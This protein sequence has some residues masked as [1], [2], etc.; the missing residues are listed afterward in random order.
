MTKFPLVVS[1]YTKNTP[2]EKWAEEL[3]NSC[4]KF[5]LEYDIEGVESLGSWHNNCCFKPTFLLKKIVQHKKPIFW[6]DADAIFLKE[7]ILLKYLDCDLAIRPFFKPDILH[8]WVCSG[9]IYLKYNEEILD[10]LKKWETFCTLPKL[11]NSDGTDQYISSVLHLT[12]PKIKIYNLPLSYHTQTS[13]INRDFTYNLE[14]IVILDR[15]GGAYSK[16]ISAVPFVDHFLKEVSL[17][18]L[19]K[20]CSIL[21][22][23]SQ[24]IQEGL[25]SPKLDLIAQFIPKN[26][27]I[28][29]AGA[30]YGAETIQLID[31]WPNAKI[32]SFE[33]NP[34][35]YN[36]LQMVSTNAKTFNLALSN[37]ESKTKLYISPGLIGKENSLEAGSS[38]LPPK[39][40][41]EQEIDI[42]CTTLDNWCEKNNISY[43][44]LLWLDIEGFELQALK[45]SP[46]SLK[47][48]KAIYT[49]TNHHDF[50]INTTKYS[51]LKA[52]LEE[53]GFK[54]LSHCYNKELQGS[55]I[56]LRN[57]V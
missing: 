7:P 30:L 51:D 17:T 20:N 52:F 33:P 12:K 4:E 3:K 31:K 39:E 23:N 46:K 49:K 22:T 36:Q 38:L 2:Y 32:F 34:A 1:F 21:K 28:I 56:F 10:L 27:V 40:A 6:V 44:D 16:K 42:Q 55:A 14:D 41:Q 35:A 37:S 29:E 50:R 19:W 24:K 5:G 8:K 9:A 43:I 48:V 25:T 26:P 18:D 11:K 57:Y 13:T 53:N 15:N 47:T 45:A 54:I